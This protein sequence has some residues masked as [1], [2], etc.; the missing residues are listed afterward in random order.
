MKKLVFILLN[1]FMFSL[2]AKA[3]FVVITNDQKAANDS[4][5]SVYLE[6]KLEKEEKELLENYVITPLKRQ[7]NAYLI[8]Y[9]TRFDSQGNY[10]RWTKGFNY[11]TVLIDVLNS[12]DIFSG[13]Y[14]VFLSRFQKEGMSVFS[15]KKKDLV[16]REAYMDYVVFRADKVLKKFEEYSKKFRAVIS[17]ERAA[18][19]VNYV[20]SFVSTEKYEQTKKWEDTDCNYMLRLWLKLSYNPE[21]KKVYIEPDY[22]NW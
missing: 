15:D 1:V 18:P 8:Y 7:L 3:E 14:W 5:V 10:E 13:Y 2:V 6:W 19:S 11:I 22:S 20:Q 12:P 4:E 21:G 17:R 9:N 16:V